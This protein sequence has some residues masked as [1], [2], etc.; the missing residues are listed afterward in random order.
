M[1]GLQMSRI[2]CI[3]FL[4]ILA[5]VLNV[6]SQVPH[7]I[8]QDYKALLKLIRSKEFRSA[9]F[10]AKATIAKRPTFSKAYEQLALAYIGVNRADDGIA[11]FNLLKSN[12]NQRASSLLG[13]AIIEKEQDNCRSALTYLRQVIDLDPAMPEPYLH[14][15]NCYSSI[16]SL[17]AAF[18]YLAF[19]QNND[20][21]NAAV[22]LGLGFAYNSLKQPEKAH[23][24][25]DKCIAIDSSI[26]NAY[27]HNGNAIHA[28]GRIDDSFVMFKIGLKKA[29]ETHDIDM[30]AAL[31]GNLANTYYEQ[32]QYTLAIE[33][34]EK[35]IQLAELT[36]DQSLKM[37]QLSNM[38]SPYKNM[39]QP[40]KAIDLLNQAQD[41]AIERG[42]STFLATILSNKSASFVDMGKNLDAIP[43]GEEALKLAVDQADSSLVASTLMN[44][45]CAYG[46]TAQFEKGLSCL[47]RAM[48]IR[49]IE[50]N[51]VQ[52][53]GLMKNMANIYREIGE[54]QVSIDTMRSAVSIAKKSNMKRVELNAIGSLGYALTGQGI[55]DEAIQCFKRALVLSDSLGEVRSRGT[56]LG[57]IGIIYKIWGDLSIGL[58]YL[59][60]ALKA[61]LA[62]SEMRGVTRH[63][64][65]RANIYET[66]GDYINA[67]SD[68]TKAMGLADSL[69]IQ[70]YMPTI[71]SNR[72]A[73]YDKLGDNDAALEYFQN[74]L[75]LVQKLKAT[76]YEASILANM[77]TLRDKMGQDSL[78]LENFT[79]SL[80]IAKQTTNVKDQVTALDNI[81][82]IYIKRGNYS[83]A[84]QI[85]QE[86]LNLAI[87]TSDKSQE[88]C[89][90]I[91]RGTIFQEKAETQNAEQCYKAALDIAKQLGSY[92][93]E[94]AA[95]RKIA[96][97][98][99]DQ[100]RYEHAI[101]LYDNA[102]QNIE[103]IR[104]NLEKQSYRSSFM[105]EN[106]KVYE[107]L[108]ILLIKL[109]RFE[110]AYNYLQRFRMRS[111]LEILS[112]NQIDYSEGITPE[113][114]E[115]LKD[116]E[117]GL[118]HI[119]EKIALESQQLEKNDVALKALSN[120]LAILQEKHQK[121]WNE[122]KFDFPN[123]A[124]MK[125]KSKPIRIEQVKAMLNS[126]EIIVEYF[127]SSAVMAAWIIQKDKVKIQI[128]DADYSEIL[129]SIL[130]LREPF[131]QAKRGEITN[132]TD[133]SFDMDRSHQ[134]YKSIF[135]PIEDLLSTKKHVIIV[136]DGI[137]YYL[138][139]EA[140]VTN[141]VDKKNDKNVIFSEYRNASYLIEK[142]SFSY[143]PSTALME[144]K[145]RDC[146]Q[147][148]SN[149]N[150]V[151]FGRPDYGPFA[152]H[153]S[154]HQTSYAANLKNIMH[155]QNA[156]LFFSDLESKDAETV[157][158]IM[159]PSLLFTG[160]NA[161]ESRFKELA[162]NTKHVYLSTHALIEESRPMYSLLALAYETAEEQDGFLHAY[163]VYNL[164]LQADLV[165]LSACETGLGQLSRGEG[166]IGMTN[167]FLYAGASSL[168]VS[169]WSV[170][171]STSELMEPFYSALEK[172]QEKAKALR[173]AKRKLM[174]MTKNRISFS[175]PFLW[176]PFI[177]VGE[178][179]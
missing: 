93:L 70:H 155:K 137:L 55:Y 145:K 17:N 78:A 13:C 98:E 179:R 20:S 174:K 167:A 171:E 59:N 170:D 14:I 110:D 141:I 117:L 118:C 79:K 156:T 26:V 130:D 173:D 88:A 69:G 16:D 132:L 125:G 19:V 92:V 124:Q 62:V 30:Q 140:L 85:N 74:A 6:N 80:Q 160:A 157:S 32:G 82:N 128:L 176:A 38:S 18:D 89:L 36:N 81:A 161:T 71:L 139:F 97:L 9:I 24:M 121:V 67:L 150:L 43:V 126:D 66:R 109:G 99:A 56:Y 149:I 5:I 48:A 123:Y 53:C 131:E 107:E 119:Y 105:Q 108:V 58:D 49:K 116:V 72:A 25:F 35:A 122:I 111:F 90:N 47:H 21:M 22:Y 64:I 91:T 96:A 76:T 168:L 65:N 40:Q 154:S 142:Y 102:I 3:F 46:N 164:C 33:H 2:T 41:I 28:L 103:S 100:K 60:Q 10:Q 177:L 8:S 101:K 166:F 146:T 127:V 120:N 129:N 68:N 75:A 51:L 77:G 23:E 15:V 104:G 4:F 106:I 175:H 95:L 12:E 178:W 172:N 31:T 169:L 57:N 37:Y 153:Q 45:G 112:P 114:H 152:L 138:P 151:A 136:P 159:K 134:L 84:E 11:Y 34:H 147:S 165:T 135:Q 73:L 148:D 143:L 94:N 144:I 63:Y 162:Q 158:R 39:G 42:D 163:E 115:Q 27:Y 61:D 83:K 44:L 50:N 52:V 54:I 113:L 1:G 29:I 87:N 133:V 86:A 7:T